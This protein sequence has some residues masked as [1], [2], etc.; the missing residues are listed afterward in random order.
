M[1]KV[2]CSWEKEIKLKNGWSLYLFFEYKLKGEKINGKDCYENYYDYAT[3]EELKSYLNLM[4]EIINS[5]GVP[6]AGAW[7]CDFIVREIHYCLSDDK[8]IHIY[9]WDLSSSKFI[10][11]NQE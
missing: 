3:D 5:F 11:S 10:P 4:S 6:Q 9:L 2:K 7:F 1:N 8:S